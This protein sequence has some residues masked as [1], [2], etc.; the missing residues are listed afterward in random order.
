MERMPLLGVMASQILQQPLSTF[1]QFGVF[2]KFPKLGFLRSE[3]VGPLP[4]ALSKRIQ[5]VSHLGGFLFQGYRV[6]PAE[7]GG[8][9]KS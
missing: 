1:F 3:A 4:H 7:R 6:L 9:V 2:D 8:A 5:I